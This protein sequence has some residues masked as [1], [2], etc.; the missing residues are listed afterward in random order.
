[1][2]VLVTGAGG[3]IGAAVCRRLAEVGYRVRG[4]VRRRP[5]NPV[6][7]VDYRITGSIDQATDWTAALDGVEAV[8]HAAARVHILAERSADP[9]AAYRSVNTQ[10]TES[11]GRQAAAA[12]VRRFVFLSSAASQA[13]PASPYGQ[14]KREAEAAL[15]RIAEETGLEVVILRPPLVYGPDAP[16]QFERLLGLLRLGLPLPI[17]AIDNRR[18]VLYLGHLVDAV[19]LALSHPDAP[20]GLFGLSDGAAVS[21][22]ELVRQ[23]AAALG[24]PARLWPCPLG[25]LRLAARLTGQTTTVE[26]L[27]GSLVADD[28]EIRQRLGWR[29]RLDLP[30]ALAESLRRVP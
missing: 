12:G 27:T 21:A 15:A 19:E 6:P 23:V 26:S 8:V 24:R 25:I 4:T 29:P 28:R 10:G 3:F 20:G 18:S 30:Q 2:T 16:G 11:L 14:S 9:L 17:A 5:A 13:E 22:P 1:M 7:A